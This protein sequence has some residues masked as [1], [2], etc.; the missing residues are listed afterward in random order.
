MED[1]YEVI[2]VTGR[3]VL[4][5]WNNTTVCYNRFLWNTADSDEYIV[6]EKS[7]EQFIT[8]HG[9]IIISGIISV[10]SIILIF[11]VIIAVSNMDAYAL[12]AMGG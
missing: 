6:R 12:T 7:M 1:E 4:C 8:E 5:V 2:I 10:I 11:M 9:G 3:R